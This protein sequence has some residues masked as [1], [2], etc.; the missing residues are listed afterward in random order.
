MSGRRGYDGEA[1][2]RR[3]LPDGIVVGA[4]KPDVPNVVAVRE[5]VCQGGHEPV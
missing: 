2:L 1:L 3:I 4:G 5:Y